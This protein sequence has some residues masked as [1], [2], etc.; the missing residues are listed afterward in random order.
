ML[1]PFA[2]QDPLLDE[3]QAAEFL[4]LK[5]TTL[6]TW[7]CTKRYALPYLKVGTSVRYRKSELESFLASRTVAA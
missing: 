6:Q 5:P 3:R 7:R 1:G 4:S 2:Q